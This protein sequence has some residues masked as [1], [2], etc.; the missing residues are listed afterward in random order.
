M[1]TAFTTLLSRDLAHAVAAVGGEAM[2]ESS[3]PS[4]TAMMRVLV[5][6]P[7]DISGYD[8]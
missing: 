7:C 5:A 1:A 6:V 4:P 3:L 2:A 8:R